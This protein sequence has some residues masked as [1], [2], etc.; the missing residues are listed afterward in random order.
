M[1]SKKGSRPRG[2]TRGFTLIELLIVVAI[3]GIIAAI[4]IPNLLNA[5]HR[6]KQ[7]RTMAD[8]RSLGTAVEN[9]QVDNSFYPRGV[10]AATGMEAH[11]S[12]TYLKNMPENDGW[13][14]I[15]LFSSDAGG[16]NYTIQSAGRDAN[17]QGCTAG[18]QTSDFD[19]DICYS[20]GVFIQWPEGRQMR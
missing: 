8:M 10:T 17:A 3:I 9:Y 5:V 19:C 20:G 18:T 4:G 6:G 1:M 13:R 7:K 16:A 15:M 12:P 2:R 11:V 14:N